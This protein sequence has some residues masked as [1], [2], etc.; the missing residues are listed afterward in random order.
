MVHSQKILVVVANSSFAEI[1][2]IELGREMVKKHHLDFPAGREKD[3]QILSDRPG[4]SF[5]KFGGER[6]ALSSEVDIH[7]HEQQV[8]AH[9]IVDLIKKAQVEHLF[10][11]LVLIA[12]PEF[13]GELRRCLPESA[14]KLIYKE[15]SK[16]FPAFL[17]DHERV[18]TICRLLDIKRPALLRL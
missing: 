2:T 18:D 14:K 10:E 15:F 16:D 12:P 8:F 1:Y 4:R 7:T 6:H 17:S 13:L 9:Q 3:G 5:S 11:R